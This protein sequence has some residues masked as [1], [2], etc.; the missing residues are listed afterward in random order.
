LQ[1]GASMIRHARMYM[2]VN[3]VSC[4]MR[5]REFCGRGLTD[6]GKIS[7]SFPC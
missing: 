7:D 2:P 1:I 3:P 4:R 6:V 5:A